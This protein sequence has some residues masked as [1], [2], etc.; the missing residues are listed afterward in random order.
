MAPRR[1]GTPFPP[2]PAS[3][4]LI[5]PIPG[6]AAR[7]CPGSWSAASVKAG[8][9]ARPQGCLDAGEHRRTLAQQASGALRH[10]S[11]ADET[12]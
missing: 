12:S 6:P 3:T 10:D 2:A 9:Q 5:L 8:P 7:G 11:R 4:S 1:Q